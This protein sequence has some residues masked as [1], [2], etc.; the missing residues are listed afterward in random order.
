MDCH[1]VQ[2]NAFG[3][4]RGALVPL[5]VGK[6]VPFAIKRVYYVYDTKRDV[7]RGFH[8]HKSLEQLLICVTGACKIKVDN[9]KETQFFDL[10]TPEKALYIGKNIWREMH[11]FSQGCVL[12]VLASEPYNP[13]EYIHDYNTFIRSIS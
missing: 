7:P 6:E 2:L 9:G 4:A 13:D 3:D 5:E 12:M 11:N 8:A 1:L 10:N